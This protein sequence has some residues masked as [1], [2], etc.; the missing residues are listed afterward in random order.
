VNDDEL[1][2]E[3][4]GFMPAD[5]E[6]AAGYFALAIPQAFEAVS[7]GYAVDPAFL[8]ICACV[9]AGVSGPWQ[10]TFS[11]SRLSGASGGSSAVSAAAYRPASASATK[12]SGKTYD[13]SDRQRRHAQRD[14]AAGS[15]V[16]DDMGWAKDRANLWNTAEAAETRKNARV[17]REVPGLPCPPELPQEQSLELG[18]RIFAGTG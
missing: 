14:H 15:I 6:E 2:C 3:P 17:A 18:E 1:H 5:A 13:H 7:A 12:R 16:A 4:G 11:T 8:C 10:S 9:D